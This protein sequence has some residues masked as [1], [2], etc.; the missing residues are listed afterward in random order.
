MA[1]S[2]QRA[3]LRQGAAAWNRW[4]REQS[5]EVPDLDDL[6]LSMCEKQLSGVD[7]AGLNFSHA[8]LRRADFR[9]ASLIGADF[10]GAELSEADLSTARLQGANMEGA[11]LGA[12]IFTDTDL[13]DVHLCKADL[14][15]ADLSGARNLRA[16]QVIGATGDEATRL[17]PGID[18]PA[19]WATHVPPSEKGG[20]FSSV[21][22][23][24]ATGALLASAACLILINSQHGPDPAAASEFAAA[25]APSPAGIAQATDGRALPVL[26]AQQPQL[27]ADDGFGSARV[28]I[29]PLSWQDDSSIEPLRP[30]GVQVLPVPAPD[31]AAVLPA[32]PVIR[33]E[34]VLAALQL[35][36]RSLTIGAQ[37]RP[38]PILAFMRAPEK[39]DRWLLELIEKHYL[40]G[41]ELTEDSVRRI[42]TGTVA[43]FGVQTALREVSRQKAAYYR[44]WPNRSYA[45]VPGTLVITWVTPN[46]AAA[47]F[48][49]DYRVT[50]RR[51]MSKSGRGRVLL[52]I[53]FSGSGAHIAAEGGH[54]FARHR[55]AAL[56]PAPF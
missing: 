21:R 36:E 4:R 18:R 33:A 27:I 48:V 34:N 15:G 14:R 55:L 2:E 50:S 49:Y 13:T 9:F 5:A 8:S 12:V 10:R 3:I 19:G 17:P 25:P 26:R 11:K 35:D 46:R 22:V 40:S 44:R 31:V 29:S 7:G 45:L 30:V 39:S 16:D 56:R 20:V 43:Y 53:A 24:G 42:Y 1:N 28:S 37:S 54:V 32:T 52:E 38:L 41:A 6:R 51:A 47:A 23:L